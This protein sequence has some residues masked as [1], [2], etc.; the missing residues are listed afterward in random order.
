MFCRFRKRKIDTRPDAHLCI[1]GE[2]IGNPLLLRGLPIRGSDDAI[3]F[4]PTV[5][6]D[7]NVVLDGG[8]STYPTRQAETEAVGFNQRGDDTT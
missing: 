7:A 6:L 4:H 3:D 8:R 1:G 2:A 5:R